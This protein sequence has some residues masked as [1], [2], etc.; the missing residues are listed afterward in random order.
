MSVDLE[1]EIDGVPDVDPIEPGGG[2]GNIF[3]DRI[4]RFLRAD[5]VM[6]G[7]VGPGADRTELLVER[8]EAVRDAFDLEDATGDR[9][10]KIGTFLVLPRQ[11]ADDDLYRTLLQ[12][13][14]LLILSNAPT[15]PVL[16]EAVR[17]YTGEDAPEYTEYDPMQFRIGAVVEDADDAQRL[18]NL[19]R[20]GKAGGY[21]MSIAPWIG[22]EAAGSAIVVDS[23][24]VPIT[25]PGNVDSDQVSIDDAYPITW[26]IA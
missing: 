17:L 5:P 8:L 25:D 10:D 1:Y 22:S 15:T 3:R 9:L 12:I 20:R 24:Q 6:R 21:R 13:Q 18:V 4:L 11:G 2:Y 26:T 23:D 16:L 14:A 19:L 7:L